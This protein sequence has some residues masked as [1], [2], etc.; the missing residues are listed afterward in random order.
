MGFRVEINTDGLTDGLAVGIR[1]GI[2]EGGV[3]VGIAVGGVV[4]LRVD[5]DIEGFV[6]GLTVGDW[7]GRKE[8]GFLVRITVGDV[9]GLIDTDGFIDGLAVGGR[10]D[11][12]VGITLTGFT[13]GLTVEI[14]LGTFELIFVGA[15]VLKNVTV[16]M[17]EGLRVETEGP[18][19]GDKSILFETFLAVGANVGFGLVEEILGSSVIIEL[20]VRSIFAKKTTKRIQFLIIL[21]IIKVLLKRLVGA[22][23]EY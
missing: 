5:I 12:F 14:K 8:D 15:L 18:T 2:L 20:E 16:G 21:L 4:G 13:V 23:V 22:V 6:D 17:E 3:V 7:L 1:L 10:V 19:V 9:V 11:N